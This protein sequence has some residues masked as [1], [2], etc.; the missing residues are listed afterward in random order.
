MLEQTGFFAEAT[1]GFSHFS[2]FPR[3]TV[4]L[5]QSS[6]QSRNMVAFRAEFFGELVVGAFGLRP[7]WPTKSCCK[8]SPA[9]AV[10]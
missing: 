8:M 5:K 10:D 1:D 7:D 3:N 4:L 2:T 6:E 9:R